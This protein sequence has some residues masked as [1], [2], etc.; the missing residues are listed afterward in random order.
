MAAMAGKLAT[1]NGREKSLLITMLGKSSGPYMYKEKLMLRSRV[2]LCAVLALAVVTTSGCLQ[3]TIDTYERFSGQDIPEDEEKVL[4]DLPDFMLDQC[5]PIM[6]AMKDRGVNQQ[7][8]DLA[9]KYGQREGR[10]CPNSTGG[11]VMDANC[12]PQGKTKAYRYDP[13]DS[14]TFQFNGFRPDGTI[15]P[16][17]PAVEFCR[18]G[19]R[20]FLNGEWTEVRTYPCTQWD[21]IT[22]FKLQADMF[23]DFVDRC[24]PAPWIKLSNGRYAACNPAYDPFA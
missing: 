9:M 15:K 5:L 21:V 6:L 2:M 16:G 18:D 12:M 4:L 11:D 17:S 23:I 14:G 8:I 22:D 19:V 1:M 20:R 24:G 10:C 7:T 3:E 13:S